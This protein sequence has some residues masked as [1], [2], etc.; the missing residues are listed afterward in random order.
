MKKI[1]SLLLVFIILLSI[2]AVVGCSGDGADENADDKETTDSNIA[3]DNSI[4]NAVE[5]KEK[6]DGTLI[7]FAA[8][9]LSDEFM[10]SLNLQLA[11][12]FAED[13]YNYQYT[14][15][16]NDT[17]LQIQQIENFVTMG[18]ELV[19]T[20]SNPVSSLKEIMLYAMDQGT[21][22]V[23]IGCEPKESDGF[24]VSGVIST[25]NKLVGTLVA[26]MAIKWIKDTYPDANSSSP[27][28]CASFRNAFNDD[29]ML[30]SDTIIQVLNESGVAEVV[31]TEDNQLFSVDEGYTSAENASTYDDEIRVFAPFSS[32]VAIGCNNYII[33][34]AT[35]DLSLYA[36][37]GSDSLAAAADLVDQSGDDTSVLRGIVN[38]AGGSP[39]ESAYNVITALVTGTQK[40]PY[41]Y[42]DPITPY[43]A[44][45]YEVA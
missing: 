36:V 17:A 26:E 43:N 34:N 42:Y 45:G 27:V 5:D 9:T 23:L 24:E 8:T 12:W 21:M 28:K 37:F 16:E 25:D 14:S 41:Y 11:E 33:S 29:N 30:R 10:N 39:A 15:C 40:A 6:D 22:I 44:V 3:Q 19:M 4:D 35:A 31:Y 1:I 7:A 2:T 13:G 32:S 38:S 18:A 20:C